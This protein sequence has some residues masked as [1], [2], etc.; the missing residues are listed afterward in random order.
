MSAIKFKKGDKVL[1]IHVPCNQP[2]IFSWRHA[3]VASFGAKQATFR[4]EDGTM[5]EKAIHISQ[6]NTT[7][8]F[9][10]CWLFPVDADPEA[11]GMD[12]ARQMIEYW[13]ARGKEKSC[14]LQDVKVMPFPKF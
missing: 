13:H 11:A 9:N 2:Y 12:V 6:L 8:A 7:H 1:V 4:R 3:E 5:F 10:G 14:N